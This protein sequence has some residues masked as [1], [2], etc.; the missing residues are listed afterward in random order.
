[1]TSRSHFD[2]LTIVIPALNEE[3]AIGG[4][5]ARCQAASEAIMKASGLSDIEIIV[6]SD[7][8]TDRTVE[9]ARSF[10]GI[11][12][13]VF[14]ENRGYGAAIKEGFRLG[15]GTLVGF[16]D[17]DGTCD[18]LYFGEMCRA[19]VEDDYDIALGSRLGPNSK[20]P[21]IR[22][23]GN[24]IFAAMLGILCGRQV[25]DTASGMRVVNRSSLGQLYPLPDRLHFTPAMSA[26]ALLNGMRIA[27]IP[28][29]YEERIG[30]SKLSVV[31]DGVRFLQTIISGVLCFRPERLFLF[32]FVG[33]A[34]LG[35]ILALYPIEYYLHHRSLQEWMIYRFVA[36]MILGIT[37][38]MFISAAGLA[39]RM[40]LFGPAPRDGYSFWAPLIAPLFEGIPLVVAETVLMIITVVLISPGIV[41]YVTTAH[42]TLHWS[43]LL[44]AA[45]CMVTIAHLLVT[46]VLLQVLNIWQYQ[47]REREKYWSSIPTVE[48]SK[49]SAAEL[50][51]VSVMNLKVESFS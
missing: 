50:G 20:M 6:V 18:P 26:R 51:R 24:R 25:V 43:R 40:S 38:L 1:M 7:G 23:L 14:E 12:V 49:P 30:R 47:Q 5:I 28:M 41:E 42:V 3:G 19:I 39:Y 8:S 9:I 13:I 31:N 44:A 33:C 37:G 16:I 34:L 36:C 46:H 32:G 2:C 4:T 22:R 27:E 45:L 29:N 10:D 17:A 11:K 48:R 15:R 35:L 21:K